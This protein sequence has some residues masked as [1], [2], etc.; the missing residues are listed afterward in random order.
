MGPPLIDK[1]RF[2]L[3]SWFEWMGRAKAQLNP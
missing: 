2:V 1:Q 3:L